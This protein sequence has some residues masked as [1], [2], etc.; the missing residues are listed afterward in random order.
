VKWKAGY[1]EVETV[2]ENTIHI[3]LAFLSPIPSFPFPP[4]ETGVRGFSPGKIF[5]F[6]IAVGAF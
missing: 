2:L 5:E 6:Y 1:S 3:I 4:L